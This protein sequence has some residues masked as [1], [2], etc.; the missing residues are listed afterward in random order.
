MNTTQKLNLLVFGAT[1]NT[2]YYFMQQA[3][4]AGHQVTAIIRNPD[5][6]D[7]KHPNLKIVKGDALQL[8][9]FASEVA[10]KD[11][12]ISSLGILEKDAFKPT[13]LCAT[14]VKNMLE[15]MQQHGVKRI[16]CVSASALDVNPEMSL[17][18]RVASRFLQW[19]LKYSYG[20]LRLME[21]ELKNSAVNWSIIRPPRLKANPVTGKYRVSVGGHLKN[22]FSI[23]R[24]DVAHCML[25]QINNAGSFQKTI[26]IAY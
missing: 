5:A 16:I 7:Y 1:R 25:Q 20:D 3:L 10:G 21:A 8:P 17:F 24:P 19:L 12:I 14:A 13:S 6:F 22:G 18:I 4:E 26:E 11:A 15:A 23:G 2:G 9:T